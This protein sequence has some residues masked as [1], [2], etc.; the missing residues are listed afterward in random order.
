[1]TD[2]A[3]KKRQ[4]CSNGLGQVTQ[5]TED[6]GGLGYWTSYAYNALDNLLNVAQ[7]TQKPC[8]GG[9]ASR[10]FGYDS[11]SR[12]SSACNPESGTVSYGYDANSNVTSKTDARGIVTCYGTWSGSSCDGLGYDAL[13]RLT[14]K[15]YSDGTATVT[16]SYD[17]S[18]CLSGPSPCYNVGRRTGMSDAAGSESWS[19]DAMGRN[20]AD[21][22]TSNGVTHT[23]VYSYNLDGSLK[24]AAA[25]PDSGPRLATLHARVAAPTSGAP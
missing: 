4:S 19:Y 15:S 20:W 24:S 12:L 11:L 25:R 13:N 16:Y 23:F 8:G 2:E 9:T 10:S 17:Q 14:K 6:P 22:R 3:G 7:G 1:V 21:Q 18:G 5:V